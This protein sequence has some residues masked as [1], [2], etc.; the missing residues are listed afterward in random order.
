MDRR[1]ILLVLAISGYGASR[2]ISSG[3]EEEGN[4]PD[5]PPPAIV[6]GTNAPEDAWP[7]QVL[8]LYDNKLRCGGTLLNDNTI[9]TA[10]HCTYR[11]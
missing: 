1:W 11:T 2:E 4:G 5:V 9:L 8:L 3:G 6:G 10:A 7:W